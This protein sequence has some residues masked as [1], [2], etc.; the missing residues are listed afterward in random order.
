MI[1]FLPGN[2]PSRGV[3]S[4]LLARAWCLSHRSQFTKAHALRRLWCSAPHGR[5]R[6]VE[7][8]HR[9][10]TPSGS[11]VPPAQKTSPFFY[12]PAIQLNSVHV[13]LVSTDCQPSYFPALCR[14]AVTPRTHL[15]CA[16]GGLVGQVGTSAV[17]SG[18]AAAFGALEQLEVEEGQP[19]LRARKCHAST[20]AAGTV[21]EKP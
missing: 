21:A 2:L 11:S 13:P 1:H 7:P 4:G 16:R 10:L 9:A 8:V 5:N 20:T 19:G 18:Q 3:L 14:P 15:A 6:G 17:A 12:S